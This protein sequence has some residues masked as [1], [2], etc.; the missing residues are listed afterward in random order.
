MTLIEVE[1]I[2]GK[3]WLNPASIDAI[4]F[5]GNDVCYVRTGEIAYKITYGIG[6]GLIATING[7]PETV[8]PV[9]TQVRAIVSIECAETYSKST[10]QYFN[11]YRCTLDNG[12][13]V[14]IFDHPDKKRNTFDICRAQG[15]ES[16]LEMTAGSSMDYETPIPCTVSHDGEWY[17][18]VAIIH[19]EKWAE[20]DAHYYNQHIP[21]EPDDEINW[22]E[23]D[24]LAEANRYFADS[25]DDGDDDETDYQ[26][27]AE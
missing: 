11:F 6:H 7:K 17:S 12:E 1:T 9:D 3:V 5:Q 27:E 8:S 2:I 10:E 20:M 19:Y 15:W 25:D 4:D 16:A 23:S 21:D 24:D 13:K 14:N 26:K 22:D 18:M